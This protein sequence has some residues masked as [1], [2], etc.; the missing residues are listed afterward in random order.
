[1]TTSD[2][3]PPPPILSRLRFRFR[4]R[5]TWHRGHRD[6]EGGSPKAGFIIALRWCCILRLT[7]M[8]LLMR[9]FSDCAE[10]LLYVPRL[11]SIFFSITSGFLFAG[12]RKTQE[13][14]FIGFYYKSRGICMQKHKGDKIQD[15][16]KHKYI[17][18]RQIKY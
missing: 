6:H 16:H 13:D 8:W 11:F 12:V 14:Y 18:I 15:T 3:I 10:V 5:L 4:F 2:P 1:M 9:L 7:Q 17:K